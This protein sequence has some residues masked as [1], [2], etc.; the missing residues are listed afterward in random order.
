MTTASARAGPQKAVLAVIAYARPAASEDARP[1]QAVR[2]DKSSANTARTSSS[3]NGFAI[4]GT[5]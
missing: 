2:S 4:S 1:L 5:V 3:A